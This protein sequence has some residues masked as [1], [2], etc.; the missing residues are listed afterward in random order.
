MA[1]AS[2]G[3]TST[4][5]RSNAFKRSRRFRT[6]ERRLGFR[7]RWGAGRLF[8]AFP[9]PS[10]IS[11][12]RPIN[13][14]MQLNKFPVHLHR[15]FDI[16]RLDLTRYFDGGF[17]SAEFKIDEIPCTFPASREFGFGDEFARDCL[18]QQKVIQTRSSGEAI[19][20]TLLIVTEG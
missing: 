7:S 16:Q 9:D 1:R 2:A 8:P 19:S 10:A 12:I 13:S 20:G 18:L 4:E 3:G 17:R 15:E 5:R 14:L 6:G 11:L